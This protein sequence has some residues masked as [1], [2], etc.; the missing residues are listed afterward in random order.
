[1][2]SRRQIKPLVNG[3]KKSLY[4]KFA[5]IFLNNTSVKKEVEKVA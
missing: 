3:K 1:M 2:L 5:S 4:C